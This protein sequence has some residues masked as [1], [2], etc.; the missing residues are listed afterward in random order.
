MAILSFFRRA[1]LRALLVLGF[2]LM[3]AGAAH[4]A[5]DFISL[6][7]HEVE[8]DTAPKL[9]RT[10]VHAS[11]LAAQ[12]AWLQA[13]GYHPISLQQVLD[14]RNGGAPLPDKA[15]L[16]SFDDGK[17]DVYTRV[18]PL[19]KLFRFPAL[20]ALVGRWL[21][22][23]AGEAVDYDGV[24]LVRSEFVSWAEVREMQGSGLVEIAS[25]SYNLHRGLLANPQGNTQP[26][27]TSR[28]YADG[29]YETDEAYHSRLQSDLRRNRDLIAKHTGTPPRAIVWPYGRTNGAAK[30]VAV[31][32]GM[33]I[34]LTLVDGRNSPQT[35]LTSLKRYL[36]EDSP[37]LQSFAE[38]LRRNWE[39]DPAR[40]V[41][42]VPAQWSSDADGGLQHFSQTL[43]QLQKLS[44]NIVFVD[45]RAS[46]DEQGKTLFPSSQRALATDVLNRISW[47]IM[48]RAG[49]PVFIDLPQTWLTNLPLLADLAR[50]VSFAGV[51][52][53]VAPDDPRAWAALAAMERWRWP[54]AVAYAPPEIPGAAAWQ[55]LPTGDL[56]VLPATSAN[57]AQ[58][59][60]VD[61]RRVL[62][63]F[64]P[65]RQVA[66]DI[67]RDMRHLDADGFRQFGLA[68]FPESGF[69][70][71]WPVLSLR[72][73]PLLP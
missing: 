42:I 60:L 31:E 37:S 65:A 54:L 53:P 4:A 71:V 14:A 51:R 19:L 11:D 44:P 3:S 43:D 62:F 12:F 68:S 9:T 1:L 27:T 6:C 13:N 41:R 32:L 26:A 69:D 16:L 33:P 38:A 73:Q 66:A 49:S 28:Q 56:V 58:I 63:E 39:A 25:H 22:V 30:Q 40:S 29:A 20:V 61:A 46:A 45:P 2:L 35:P 50:H 48:T 8:S 36:I 24:S 21:D 47:Q 67:A 15:I 72:S 10:A 64:D 70:L 52:M 18:F 7:Y 23:P 59:P 17:K 34:G 57:R 55:A 5:G